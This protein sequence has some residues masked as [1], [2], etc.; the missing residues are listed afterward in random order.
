MSP[1]T[2]I[3]LFMFSGKIS[4]TESDAAEPLRLFD[5]FIQMGP[6]KMNRCTTDLTEHAY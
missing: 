6:S 2:R 1:F 4:S 3:Y 5:S